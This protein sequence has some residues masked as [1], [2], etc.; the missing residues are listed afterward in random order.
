[1]LVVACSGLLLAKQS[2]A[3]AE[4]MSCAKECQWGKD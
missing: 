1:M 2:H 4:R 3:A